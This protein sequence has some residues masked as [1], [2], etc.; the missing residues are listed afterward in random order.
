MGSG[1]PAHFVFT[2]DEMSHQDWADAHDTICFVRRDAA[3]DE[4]FNPV[5]RTGKCLMLIVCIAADGSY[6]RPALIIPR[7][8]FDDELLLFE[9][10]TDK[11]ELYSQTLS[12]RH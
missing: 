10:T 4:I 5:S 9:F 2:M 3:D 6:M 1:A 8:T 7:K 12:F 11:V